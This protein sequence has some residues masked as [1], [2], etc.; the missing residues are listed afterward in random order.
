MKKKVKKIYL[1]NKKRSLKKI[2][3]NLMKPRFSVFRSNSHI[4]AQLI[5]DKA[6]QTLVSC[7]TLDSEFKKKIADL[8]SQETFNSCTQEAAFAVG[9]ELAKR[10]LEKNIQTVVFDRGKCAY[11]GRIQ[12]IAEGA[13]QQGLIF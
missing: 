7:S 11:H 4:Y 3:G 5:D 9:I 6:G 2:I 10:A 8:N 13:R 12:K 1:Q